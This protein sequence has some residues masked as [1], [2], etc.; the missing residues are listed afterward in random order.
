MSILVACDMG[1]LM[2]S[3]HVVRLLGIATLSLVVLTL[4]FGYWGLGFYHHFRLGIATVIVGS[5]H[6]ALVIWMHLRAR[7]R[8]KIAR[9]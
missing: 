4:V 7:K 3:I 6:G 2:R 5:V 8:R 9:Q 1:V